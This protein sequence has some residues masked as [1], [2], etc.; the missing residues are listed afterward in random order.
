MRQ[1][2]FAF[3][4]QLQNSGK[5][6]VFTPWP[7]NLGDALIVLAT[8]QVFEDFGIRYRLLSE[9]EEY[10]ESS[11][12][13]LGGGGCLNPL[14]SDF[15][16]NF[17]HSLFPGKRPHVVILPHS[18]KG[19]D[20]LYSGFDGRLTV[21]AREL[22]SYNY[23]LSL[24]AHEAFIYDDLA[25]FLNVKEEHLC[26]YIF[27]R[28]FYSQLQLS[29]RPTLNCF[30]NDEEADMALLNDTAFL[31]SFDLSVSWN[32][33][34]SLEMGFGLMKLDYALLY[35]SISWFLT[36][37]SMFDVIRTNRLHVGIAGC[38]L[39]KEVYLYDNSYG[40]ISSVYDYSL[41]YRNDLTVFLMNRSADI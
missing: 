31:P 29:S 15:S 27:F 17:I 6:I 4:Q 23:L 35:N 7:G 26:P 8:L 33:K 18:V 16:V 30:R 14:Y 22:K 5:Q 32:A 37:I 39:G 1:C 21:F 34:N 36:Y 9:N 41:S 10:S 3:L 38:L 28:K 19:V 20:N 13:V 24:G 40:K 2:P 25:I 11:V 12:Y